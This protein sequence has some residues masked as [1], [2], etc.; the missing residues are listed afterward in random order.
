MCVFDKDV[1]ERDGLTCRVDV[2]KCHTCRAKWSIHVA[3]GV[4][5]CGEVVCGSKLCVS[6][7][8]GDKLCVDKLCVW[9]SCVWTSCVRTSCV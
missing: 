8:C 4:C 1:F 9:T 7:L 3:R 5:V 6:K 2:A